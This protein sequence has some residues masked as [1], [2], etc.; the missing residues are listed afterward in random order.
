MFQ[1]ERDL[2]NDFLDILI[3]NNPW[4]AFLI[5][6]EFNYQRGKT[7]IITI[8]ANTEVIAIEAK[9]IKWREALQQAYRNK[10]YADKSYI[11]LPIE[12]AN[13]A[14]KYGYEF[15]R[16][17]IGLCS[18]ENNQ[19]IIIREASTADAPIQPWLREEAIHYCKS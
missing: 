3:N 2:V 1:F 19:I 13:V 15:E 6:T 17:G 14:V 11:L 4:D 7:D 16:R 18:I 5:G 9:L 8:S 12:T 10:C